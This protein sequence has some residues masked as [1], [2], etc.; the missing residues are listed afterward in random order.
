MNLTDEQKEIIK[1]SVDNFEEKF[2]EMKKEFF[3]MRYEKND[4]ED[5]AWASFIMM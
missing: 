4:S 1:G 5:L 2:L 3:N